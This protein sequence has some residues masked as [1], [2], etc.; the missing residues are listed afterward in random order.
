MPSIK[1]QSTKQ[2]NFTLG[3]MWAHVHTFLGIV[4][5]SPQAL[6]LISIVA[7]YRSRLHAFPTLLTAL[8]PILGNPLIAPRAILARLL[9]RRL[10]RERALMILPRTANHLAGLNGLTTDCATFA[11]A[12]SNPPGLVG[13]KTL[14][15]GERRR[16]RRQLIILGAAFRFLAYQTALGLVAACGIPT[17]P[18]ALRLMA[19]ALARHVAVTQQVADRPC[20]SSRALGAAARRAFFLCASVFGAKRGTMRSFAINLARCV[21]RARATRLAPRLLA[22]RCAILITD[23]LRAVPCTMRKTSAMA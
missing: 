7:S 3:A 16:Q 8:R 10:V 23:R 14:L 5:A 11:P 2:C 19:Y 18:S 1:I 15:H 13:V 17:I 4:G 22:V 21:V 12:I 6:L 9:R 20:A